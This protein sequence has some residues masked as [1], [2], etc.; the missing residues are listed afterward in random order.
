MISSSI[1]VLLSCLTFM[2]VVSYSWLIK[3]ESSQIPEP[4]PKYGPLPTYKPKP[5]LNRLK[6]IELC[7]KNSPKNGKFPFS[8]VIVNITQNFHI[9]LGILLDFGPFPRRQ[10]R[11]WFGCCPW[12]QNCEY[13]KAR[14]FFL[15]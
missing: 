1:L 12:P 8:G 9:S 3:W 15:Q 5:L 13:Y 6:T 10:I 4:P 7:I 11:G 14:Y 2:C